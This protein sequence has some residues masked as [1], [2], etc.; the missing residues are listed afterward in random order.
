MLN[1]K[2]LGALISSGLKYAI[3]AAV[4]LGIAVKAPHLHGDYI[5]NTVGSQ[6]VYLT[7]KSGRAGGT[8]FAIKTPSGDV[9]TLTNAHVCGLA[10]DKG[11]IYA[12]TDKTRSI[13]L[14]VI[15]LYDKADL[16]L[17]SKMPGM[18]GLKVA[19]SVSIGEELG[20]VGHPKLLPLTL[21]RGQLLGYGMVAVLVDTQP[22]KE[23]TGMYKTVMSIFGPV[24]VEISR[25]AF[26]SITSFGG[27]SGSPTVN[28]FGNVVG[29]LYAGDNTSNWGILVPLEAV[30]DFIK[31]Y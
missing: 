4:I 22:C 25:S 28:I 23:D 11:I 26:T 17:V 5:R 6:V 27:S 15:E 2:K 14:K 10:D 13:P 8:G 1:I 24:C 30:V 19:S 20:L 12:K 7:E 18:T 31:D 16:C 3:A 9:L 21:T 29:V